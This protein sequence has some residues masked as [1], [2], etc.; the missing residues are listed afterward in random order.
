MKA[1]VQYN[2][3][4][5]TA[6]ADISDY[7]RNSLQV[8]LKAT[9]PEYNDERYRCDGC[10]IYTGERSERATIRFVCYDNKENK[11]V[12]FTPLKEYNLQDVFGIFKRLNIVIGNNIDDIEISNDDWLDL[13]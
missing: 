4:V 8:Y 6:A 10:Y 11:D 5:G 1:E 3:L 12:Y 2:D 13:E 9:F 7:Y